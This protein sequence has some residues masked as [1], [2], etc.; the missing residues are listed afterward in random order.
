MRHMVTVYR[1]RV[2]EKGRRGRD[3]WRELRWAMS[4]ERATAW[5]AANMKA[6][7]MVPASGRDCYEIPMAT[8]GGIMR[9]PGIGD[10]KW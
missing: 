5:S 8:S 2:L 7:D 4:I 10:P 3:R 9:A 6:V 1:W